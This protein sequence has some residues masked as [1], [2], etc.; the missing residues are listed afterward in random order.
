MQAKCPQ[1]PMQ[2]T[3]R[4]GP[5]RAHKAPC[6]RCGQKAILHGP[7]CGCISEAGPWEQEELLPASHRPDP[8]LLISNPKVFTC[9]CSALNFL[10]EP[11][12]KSSTSSIQQLLLDPRLLYPPLSKEQRFSWCSQMAAGWCF[13][14]FFS[15]LSPLD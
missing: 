4:R 13:Q 10:S 2:V 15:L 8:A 1:K 11:C 5:H 14:F 3:L 7:I 6:S 9:F 12:P